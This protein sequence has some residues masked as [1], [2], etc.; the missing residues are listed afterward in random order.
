MT[1]RFTIMKEYLSSRRNYG[2][3]M[4]SY[5]YFLVI[6]HFYFMNIA[7]ISFGKIIKHFKVTLKQLIIAEIAIGVP[8]FLNQFL[9]KSS[10]LFLNNSESGSS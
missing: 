8:T 5:I 3:A 4:E 2:P 7:T 10:Y 9:E 6:L 1:K